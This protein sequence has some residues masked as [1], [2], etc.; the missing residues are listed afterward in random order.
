MK[1][2]EEWW[3]EVSTN[4]SKMTDWLYDQ[5]RGE[6]T[7]AENIKGLIDKYNLKGANRMVIGKIAEQ[8]AQHAEW[9]GDL[10]MKQGMNP[11]VKDV[12]SRYWKETILDDMTF[13]YVCAV[14]HHAETM[15][16]ERIELL[17]QDEK[18]L[19]IA[20]TF[21]RIRKDELFHAKAFAALS[22]D[23]D[24]EKARHNHEKGMGAIGLVI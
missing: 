24:I 10:L 4:P 15:R 13:S 9:I 3:Q 18:F 20:E 22:T 14:A 17:A 12:E 1:T 7:A 2:T 11:E 23:E 8:E 21:R 6:V 19:D 5:Y 16:L